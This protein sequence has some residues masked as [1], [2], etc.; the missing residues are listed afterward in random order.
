[1]TAFDDDLVDF[2]FRSLLNSMAADTEHGP[3]SLFPGLGSA[4][5]SSGNYP[6]MNSTAYP[7]PMPNTMSHR[8]SQSLS[9][10]GTSNA[11]QQQLLEG[12]RK[13]R[14]DSSQKWSNRLRAAS[15]MH[16]NGLISSDDKAMMKDLILRGNREFE[17][18]YERAERT[19]NWGP[20]QQMLRVHRA[21]QSMNNN[22]NTQQQQQQQQPSQQQQPQSQQ[23]QQTNHTNSLGFLLDDA[24]DILGQ[25]FSHL[26][27]PPVN[28]A[29]S[30]SRKRIA[31]RS[32]PVQRVRKVNQPP[33][34][35]APQ[36]RMYARSDAIE[37]DQPSRRTPPPSLPIMWPPPQQQQQPQQQQAPP[38]HTQ[39]HL[40][41]FHHPQQLQSMQQQQQQ[42]QS[43]QL[44]QQQQQP[45][46]VPLPPTSLAVQAAAKMVASATAALNTSNNNN[47]NTNE[48]GDFDD[49]Y[50][51]RGQKERK[52]ER[53][54]QRRILVNKG[55]EDLV[56]IL[57]LPPAGKG[58]GSDADKVT[59]LNTAIARIEQLEQ[60]IDML[61][62]LL[63]TSQQMQ[64]QQQYQYQ[65][66]R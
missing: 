53:E 46:R 44:Q 11:N 23:Q 36:M 39:H 61:N 63:L 37:H 32:T 66:Q 48:D 9:L 64:Q 3:D 29:T 60:H 15:D 27:T 49:V 55:F 4:A 17:E 18:E 2:D 28:D 22:N 42:Q 51:S 1:M 57:K 34:S 24:M 50:D 45:S 6:M 5:I 41:M 56:K 54:R 20:V 47:N 65:Q 43:M 30:T 38:H 52:N 58:K 13:H 26:A 8:T 12:F 7:P 33:S 40:N 14:A 31:S 25:E 59:I 10:T 21:N 19:H 16:L 35:T 62:S